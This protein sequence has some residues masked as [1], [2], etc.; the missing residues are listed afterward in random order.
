MQGTVAPKKVEARDDGTDDKWN[1]PAMW[2]C[3]YSGVRN[4]STLLEHVW[5]DAYLG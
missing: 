1:T 4:T 3:T 5:T 2:T